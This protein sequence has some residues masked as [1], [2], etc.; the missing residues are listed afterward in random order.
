MN[1]RRGT[2][3]AALLAAV[4]A[5]LAAPGWS[6]TL[7]TDAYYDYVDLS[8]SL[9]RPA[10]F[11]PGASSAIAVVVTNAGPGTADTPVVLLSGDVDVLVEGVSGCG[12]PALPQ[13]TCALAPIAPSSTQGANLLLHIGAFARG[14]VVFGAAASSEAIET[15]PGD[16]ISVVALPLVAEAD[17]RVAFVDTKPAILADGRLQWTVS[18]DNDGPSAAIA[19]T[20]VDSSTSFG[21]PLLTECRTDAASS[22]PGS[23]NYLSPGGGWSL[24]F[25]A[26]PL[27]RDNP[28]IQIGYSV[29]PRES[30]NDPGNDS[31][32][33]VYRDVLLIDAFE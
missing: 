26:P 24:L 17:T 11:T 23:S 22:C 21:G 2:T 30:G 6:E 20:A 25:I 33:L 19:P 18:V 4:L 31:V 27:S 10:V 7:R 12:A 9:Q 32:W 1:V 3:A 15:N 8:L 29:Q 28:E 13:R 5:T 16:E 14:S